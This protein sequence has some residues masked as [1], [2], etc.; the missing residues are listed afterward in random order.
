MPASMTCRLPKAIA[1]GRKKPHRGCQGNL[2][3]ALTPY[4]IIADD[5]PIAFNVFMHVAINSASGAIEVLPPLSKPGD[6]IVFRAEMEL[7]IG[8]TAC[9]AGQSNNFSFKPIDYI[10]SSTRPQ[11]LAE[12]DWSTSAPLWSPG[13]QP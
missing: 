9:S 7:I 1:R 6:R 5:I 11:W 4:G 12:K 2:E 3:E 10:V 8:L 13:I